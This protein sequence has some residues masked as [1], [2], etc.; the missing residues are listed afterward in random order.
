MPHPLDSVQP[1]PTPLRLNEKMFLV[2]LTFIVR[3]RQSLRRGWPAIFGRLHDETFATFGS[4]RVH[5]DPALSGLSGPQN[6]LAFSQR[7]TPDQL[8]TN[9]FPVIEKVWL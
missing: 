4:T 5:S 7:T 8:S 6:R 9:T 2:T 1:F 3:Q